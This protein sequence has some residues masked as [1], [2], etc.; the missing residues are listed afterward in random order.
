MWIWELVE[1]SELD[2]DSIWG[3]SA[4]RLRLNPGEY[5]L[6]YVHNN[7]EISTPKGDQE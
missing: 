5:G 1:K 3:S 4:R 6:N 2:A 7:K